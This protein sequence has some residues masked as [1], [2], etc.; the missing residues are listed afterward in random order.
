MAEGGMI[1]DTRIDLG[2]MEESSTRTVPLVQHRQS[3]ACKLRMV[4]LF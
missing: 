2:Q 3:P 1:D 4:H